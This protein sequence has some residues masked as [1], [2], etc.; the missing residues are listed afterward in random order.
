[1]LKRV[2]I[3][4]AWAVMASPLM[5][6]EVQ[7]GFVRGLPPTQTTTAAF[8]RLVNPGDEAWTITAVYSEAAATV[9]I[10]EHVH[11]GGMMRMQQ[12]DSLT[13]APASELE[14]KPGGLHLM[15]M[16]L[17]RPLQEGEEVTLCFENDRGEVISVALPVVS[18]VNE[19]RHH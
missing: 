16:G 14:F 2:V 5:A 17:T 10:H 9:E 15:L 11:E 13:V 12:R 19:H 7:Q 4:L 1:M 6:L 18:V 8:F 3:F